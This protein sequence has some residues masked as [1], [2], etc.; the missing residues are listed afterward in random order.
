MPGWSSAVGTCGAKRVLGRRLRRLRA[1]QLQHRK[2]RRVLVAAAQRGPALS[3]RAAA[4]PGCPSPAWRTCRGPARCRTSASVCSSRARILD[5]FLKPVGIAEPQHVPLVSE[6]TV[7]DPPALVQ[8]ADEVL[9]RHPRIVEE[10]LVEVEVVLIARGRE[11]PAHHPAR[12]VGIINAL[13]PLCFGASGSVRTNVSSTSASCA[14]DVHTFCP[15]TTKWSP[16]AVARVRNDARSDPAP[17][18]LIPSDAVISARRIGTAHFCCC[19]RRSERDQRRGDDADA[20]R[21]VSL[22]DPPSR[23]FQLIDVLL[24]DRGVAAA[25]LGRVVRAPASRCRTSA[26]ASDGPTRAHDYSTTI[27]RAPRP[28]AAN[29]RRGRRR[30]RRGR[31]RRRRQMSAARHSRPVHKF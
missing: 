21:V 29:S 4:A 2:R 12:S 23:Q 20:L 13:M 30:T 18:S 16:S 7:G 1:E 19:S 10:H 9:G 6:R 27:D 28:R 11:R 3:S 22:V 25:E 8:R 5:H 17:G 31:L 15:L 24:Q 14:P 26:A